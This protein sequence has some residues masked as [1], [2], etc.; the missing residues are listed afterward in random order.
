M[1][2]CILHIDDEPEIREL[3]KEALGSVGYEVLSVATALEAA[4]ATA[5]RTPDLIVSDFNLAEGDGLELV[6]GLKQR[7]PSV[8]VALLTGVLIDPRGAEQALGEVVSVYLSKTMPLDDI[9]AEIARLC[10]A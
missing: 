7:F 10:P 9:L 4:R 2:K 3:L 1:S 6:R 8:P 5:T